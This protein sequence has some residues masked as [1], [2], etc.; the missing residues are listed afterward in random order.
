[1]PSADRSR[2]DR[3]TT[4]RSHGDPAV[5][6]LDGELDSGT[7]LIMARAVAQCLA[8]DPAPEVVVLDLSGVTL[9]AI[10]QR[11]LELHLHS[12]SVDAGTTGWRFG[13]SIAGRERRRLAAAFNGGFRLSVGAGGFASYGHVVVPLRDGI[14]SIVT[15]ADLVSAISSTGHP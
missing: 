10:D 4:S 1:M 12:G 15:Y 2:R 11:L 8:Q 9:L 13:P 14:G 7:V 6:T 3:L 5:V